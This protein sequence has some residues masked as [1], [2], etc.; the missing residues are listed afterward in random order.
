MSLLPLPQPE[1][2]YAPFVPVRQTA[3]DVCPHCR[4]EVTMHTFE[5]DG[6]PIRTYDC[7]Q[8]GAVVPMRSA[9]VN[10]L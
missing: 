9:V 6:H 2:C 1:V 8:H 3:Y 5:C 10:A 7:P 4:R